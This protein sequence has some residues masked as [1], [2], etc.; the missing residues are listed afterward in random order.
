M[1]EYTM[2]PPNIEELSPEEDYSFYFE[3]FGE[4]S[5]R[6]ASEY[7]KDP[8]MKLVI[9]D[10]SHCLSGQGPS[11]ICIPNAL[12]KANVSNCQVKDF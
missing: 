8:G 1:I 11:C 7:T 5:P 10:L 9:S 6:I 12:R 4:V 2:W 3:V